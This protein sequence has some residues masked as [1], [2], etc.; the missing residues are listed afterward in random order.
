MNKAKKGLSVKTAQLLM[1]LSIFVFV[2]GFYGQKIKAD[3]APFPEVWIV[4]FLKTAGLPLMIIG[5]LAALAMIVLGT[6]AQ[7]NGK[8]RGGYFVPY[9]FI[10]PAMAFLVNFTVYPLLNLFYLSVFRGNVLRPAKQ[11]L[12]VA[13]FRTLF[14]NVEFWAALK[15]TAIY[16]VSVVFF[17]I[18]F[19]LLFAV[20]FNRG[21]KIDTAGQTLIFLP[22]LIASVSIAYIWSWIMDGHSYGILNMLLG[23]FGK[24]PHK[25]LDSSST[26]LMCIV[27]VNVWK[28]IGY[29]SLMILSA[30]KSI[31]T[32]I[33]EAA[34]LDST[35]KVKCFFKITIPMLTPQ[36]FFM[37]ITIT[38]SS[39]K[40]FDSVNIMTNGGPGSSTEVI[41]RL[42]YD[43]VS[44]R[45]NMMGS[46]AALSLVLV[47][48]LSV[49]SYV[50]FHS[51][52]K[53]VYYQ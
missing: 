45:S 5:A 51:L 39:F 28:S 27:V 33:Y 3:G 17:L 31:P 14:N 46:G 47:C 18:L 24:V 53:K 2:A 34:E 37:L 8:L 38:I 13:N 29:Y 40:V 16:S 48:I 35:S 15:N 6:K 36:L 23:L 10:I 50:Y 44:T 25:W 4:V 12:G 20:W 7:N 41:T 19:A 11:F 32:E 1:W 26:A 21:R 42:L 30:M 52:E 43:Y 22:H 49:L 9:L